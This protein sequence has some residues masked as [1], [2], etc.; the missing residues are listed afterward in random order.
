MK[1]HKKHTCCNDSVHQLL[2]TQVTGNMM[3]FSEA[4]GLIVVVWLLSLASS[5]FRQLVMSILYTTSLIMQFHPD[6]V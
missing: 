2:Q 5:C 6:T 1:G 4:V 3:R